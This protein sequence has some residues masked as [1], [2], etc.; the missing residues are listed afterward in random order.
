MHA[1]HERQD[2]HEKSG[3]VDNSRNDD[4][5]NRHEKMNKLFSFKFVNKFNKKESILYLLKSN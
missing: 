3:Q 1:L 2:F 5:R 4:Q